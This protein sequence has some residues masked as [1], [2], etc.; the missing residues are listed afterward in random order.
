MDHSTAVRTYAAERYVLND[1]EEDEFFRY[2]AH[3]L[4]CPDCAEELWL[5]WEFVALVRQYFL[6]LES[7]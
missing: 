7:R 3:V 1:M 2:E 6:S 5:T 4:L